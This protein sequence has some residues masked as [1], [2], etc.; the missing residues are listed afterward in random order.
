[1]PVAEVVNITP[2]TLIELPKLAHE[3]L[4]ILIA[5]KVVGLGSAVKVGEN[6]GVKINF[7]GDL[8]QRIE[9]LGPGGQDRASTDEDVN[10]FAEA[11]LAGDGA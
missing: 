5:N 8:K 2:G 6:F 4:E 7:I 11:L 1:M 3:D 9:A 10:A